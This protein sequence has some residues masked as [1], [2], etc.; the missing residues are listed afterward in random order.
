MGHWFSK[1]NK[2]EKEEEER[3]KMGHDRVQNKTG[4]IKNKVD[5]PQRQNKSCNK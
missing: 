3:N 5:I 1:Q 4:S 2:K